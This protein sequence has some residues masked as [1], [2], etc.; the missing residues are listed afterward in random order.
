MYIVLIKHFPP[1]FS[2]MKTVLSWFA[3]EKQLL[4]CHNKVTSKPRYAKCISQILNNQYFE[5]QQKCYF[6]TFDKAGL[7]EGKGIV[8][9]RGALKLTEFFKCVLDI[10]R[11]QFDAVVDTWWGNGSPSFWLEYKDHDTHTVPRI[12]GTAEWQET[13]HWTRNYIGHHM[14]TFPKSNCQMLKSVTVYAVKHHVQRSDTLQWMSNTTTCI[15]DTSTSH[16]KRGNRPLGP[17][18]RPAMVDR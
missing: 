4:C 17:K 12:L 6:L 16:S 18:I 5:E 8:P 11:K 1:C 9:R 2:K 10:V 15:P 3:T 14:F 13:I 7:T